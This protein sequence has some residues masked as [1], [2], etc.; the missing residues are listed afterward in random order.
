MQHR[1]YTD[2]N[3]A[4][5]PAEGSILKTPDLAHLIGFGARAPV[6][7]VA[8]DINLIAWFR[9]D[10]PTIYKNTNTL[11]SPTWVAL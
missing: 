2:L 7:G 4:P 10:D 6:D 1:T 11:A 9:R 3:E 5:M 8:G